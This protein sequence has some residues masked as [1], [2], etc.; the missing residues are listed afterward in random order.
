MQALLYVFIN[1]GVGEEI[2]QVLSVY[3]LPLSSLPPVALSTGAYF[4]STET[5]EKVFVPVLLSGVPVVTNWD[6]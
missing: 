6:A 1:R 2:A 5:G 4:F 3:A